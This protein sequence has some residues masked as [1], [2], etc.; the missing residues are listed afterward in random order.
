MRGIIA[1]ATEKRRYP[2]RRFFS[3]LAQNF[4]GEQ[5]KTSEKERI[6]MRTALKKLL[7]RTGIDALVLGLIEK[8]ALGLIKKLQAAADFARRFLDR[9]EEQIT[10]K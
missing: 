4:H 10:A 5:I 7:R 3:A 9:V 6:F 8:L 2:S 1:R